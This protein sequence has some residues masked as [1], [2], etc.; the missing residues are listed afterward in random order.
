[1]SFLSNR[2][3]IKVRI[4]LVSVAFIAG[5]V[6]IGGVYL[7]GSGKVAAAFEDAKA[8]AALEHRTSD[9]AA[10]TIALKVASRDVR[11]GRDSIDLQK[12][13]QGATELSDGVDAL[14]K[15]PRG[16]AFSQQISAMKAEIGAITQQF[17]IVQKLQEGLGATGSGGLADQVEQSSQTLTTRIK[18]LISDEDTID[19]ERLLGALTAMRRD[20]AEFKA[21]FD[22]S[23]TGEWEVSFG[24]FERV[25]K[26][27]EI[28][29]ETKESL[30]GVF[31]QYADAFRAWSAAEKDFMLAAEKVTGG[32]DL[33]GPI[34]QDLDAKVSA[35]GEAAGARL[36][37]AEALTKKII[38]ITMLLALA[39]GLAS[40]LFV[41]RTT[42]K[43]LG[44]LRDAMLGLAGG[45]LHAEIPALSRRDEIGQMAKAVQTFKE[46]A[47]DRERLEHEAHDQRGMTEAERQ[48]NEAERAARASEQERVVAIVAAGHEQLSQG[49]LTFRIEQA[50]APDYQ[51]LKG[52]FNAA[53]AQLQ[54][55]MTVIS[56]TTQRISV[57]AEEASQASDDLSRRTEQQAASLEQTATALDEITATVKKAAE[58]ASHA[59]A[60]VAAADNDAKKSTLVVRQAV[61]A[62]DAIA[63]SARQISQII[64]AIDEIAF[65]TNLLAL[66]AGVEAARAGEAGRG[67]AVV[68]SEVRA[69]AQRSA[70]AAKEIKGLISASTVQ[71]DHGVKLVAETGKSLERIM[72][73]VADVNNVI[74]GIA[75]GAKEQATGLDE[76]NSAINLVDQMT[77]RNAAMVVESTAASRSLSQE[78]SQLSAL[79]GRFQVGS[80]ADD[81]SMRRE[82]QKIAPHAFRPAVA[83]GDDAA[84]AAR[85]PTSRIRTAPG[86]IGAHGAPV[87]RKANG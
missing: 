71:V 87:I 76:V 21:T 79:I 67:F 19:A 25:L 60:V 14:A 3:T 62:M 8:F 82:L 68:A 34:L 9:V 42:A 50:F 65:Q 4:A 51:K 26:R 29:Q 38:L 15:A 72:A 16:E 33:I 46:A 61:A 55:T 17:A 6:I 73:Q 54:Q 78:T 47:M 5:L 24:R 27:I 7:I 20:Q 37:A 83:A 74:I 85:Q 81:A 23:L 2:L 63:Q 28:P 44:Q 58:G 45:D 30:E 35:E 86:A 80:Q 40:A 56:G 75:A 43:P 66:N 31:R 10:S 70:E 41:G 32:F 59:R 18:A 84:A 49:N 22:Y 77:Q 64:G 53:I 12:F 69:L 57:N 1:M 48:R 52:D 36:A 13:S 11:F 39:G